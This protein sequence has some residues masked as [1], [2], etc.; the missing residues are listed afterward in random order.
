MYK[1]THRKIFN[2]LP[3]VLMLTLV[4]A[5]G[6][7]SGRYLLPVGV[8]NAENVNYSMGT[9]KIEVSPEMKLYEQVKKI[10]DDKYIKGSEV[11]EDAKA[12]GSIK[13]LVESYGDPYTVFFPPAESKTFKTVVSGTFSGVGMEVGMKD[14]VITVISPL[15]K[16]PAEK[17]GM[18]PD[19][20][21][22]K[23]NGT[24]TEG[25]STDA[26]VQLIRGE[27]GTPVTLTVLRKGEDKTKEIT[28]V[29]DTIDLPVVDT[30]TSGNVFIISLYSFSETSAQKFQEALQEFAKSGKK[31]LVIDLRNNP[32]GYLEAAVLMSSF[33]FPADKSIVSEDF[34]RTGKKEYSHE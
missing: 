19:D 34:V 21:I 20:K 29:R 14:G 13:G 28:I 26:A 4:F 30:Q 15:K 1:N 18:K 31:K 10:L 8:A 32:G 7:Y 16:S 5:V 3:K 9:I 27:K 25:M 11:K 24:T 33:F 6:V 17:A 22:L 23:I 2:N 12:Y